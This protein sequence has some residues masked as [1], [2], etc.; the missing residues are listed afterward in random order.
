MS[1]NSDTSTVIPPPRGGKRICRELFNM[2]DAEIDSIAECNMP[3][4]TTPGPWSFFGPE[5]G[6]WDGSRAFG[7]CAC[8]PL[9]VGCAP[10][11]RV[12]PARIGDKNH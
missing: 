9:R 5:V 2:S 7:C 11:A 3:I 4:S 6:G 1:S 8:R 10:R 12:P